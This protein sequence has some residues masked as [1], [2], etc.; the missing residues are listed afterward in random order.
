[1]EQ[2]F[3]VLVLQK[4]DVMYYRCI[5][6]GF[7]QTEEPFWLDE[8]YASP[9]NREDVGLLNRNIL[10]S[11]YVAIILSAAFDKH[12]L[13]LDYAGGYG[14]FTRL[15]R[16]AGFDF[17]W[18]DPYTKNIF[19][20]GCEFQPET[21]RVIEAVTCFESF[22]HFVEPLQEIEKILSCS[23]SVLF[24]TTFLP[25]PLPDP[26]TWWYY[27]REHGQHVSFY[28][29]S[30][31]AS[32]ARK[33]GLRFYS[34]GEIHVLTDRVMPEERIRFLLRWKNYGAYR[35]AVHDLVPKTQNDY[36][37]IQKNRR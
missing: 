2:R 27:G 22:E 18:H 21:Q 36:E 12:E 32:L 11:H 5:R 33:C 8:A 26:G 23:K 17:L 9:I 16:D 24:S 1:M 28:T 15:M 31:C 7:V 3:H 20:E 19:A 37:R 13:F 6:C 4:Y 34:F 10:F 30:A 35:Y 29:K 14:V 25:E